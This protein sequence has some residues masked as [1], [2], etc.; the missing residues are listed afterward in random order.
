MS[1]AVTT[2]PTIRTA[3]EICRLYHI[4][5]ADKALLRDPMTPREFLQALTGAGRITGAI[6]FLAQVLPGREAVRWAC[7]CL[8]KT[9]EETGS[10]PEVRA[11]KAARAWVDQPAQVR[12]FEAWAAA[13]AAGLET[14]GGLVA[15][16]A[17]FSGKTLSPPD[18][19]PTP[20]PE[21][22]TG[23]TASAALLMAVSAMEPSRSEAALLEYL[24]AGVSLAEAKNSAASTSEEPRPGSGNLD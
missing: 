16:A 9:V 7:Q 6:Q 22:L 8:D 4:E 15:A 13:E 23:E 1:S 3:A 5:A 19:P 18:L 24:K 12:C 20:P 17:F 21:G 11:L 10:P 2:R 14:A